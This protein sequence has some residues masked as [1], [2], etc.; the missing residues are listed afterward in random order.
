MNIQ[1]KRIRDIM[2]EIIQAVREEFKVTG[3]I[4]PVLSSEIEITRRVV[5]AL[6]QTAIKVAVESGLH[7]AHFYE[8]LGSSSLHNLFHL[9]ETGDLAIVF[10]IEKEMIFL[11]IPKGHWRYKDSKG[12]MKVH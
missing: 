11:N 12:Y 10:Y 8:Q 4:M 7:P 1:E 2:D 3:N 6:R 5:A 9:K